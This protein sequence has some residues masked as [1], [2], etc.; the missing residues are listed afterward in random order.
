M[1][2]QRGQRRSS[3]ATNAALDCEFPGT[4]SS[5][6]ETKAKVAPVK[7]SKENAID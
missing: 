3:S 6:L 2:F 4:E 5:A 7:Q 1:P